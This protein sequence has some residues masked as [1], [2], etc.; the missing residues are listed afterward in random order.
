VGDKVLIKLQ[1]YAQASVINQPYPKLA[2]KYFGPYSVLAHIGKATYRLE[3]PAD[4]QV[5]NVFHVS[6]LKD[7]HPDFTPVFLAL[8]KCPA[9][10]NVDTTHEL[11]LGHRLVKKGN[12][13]IPQVLIKWTGLPTDAAT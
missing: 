8:P 2:Y 12:M 6:R 5:H 10:D 7:Y 1:P 13:A 3:L 9:L 4:S 11:V